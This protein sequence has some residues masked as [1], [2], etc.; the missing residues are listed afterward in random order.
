M[1]RKKLKDSSGYSMETSENVSLDNCI[2]G[3]EYRGELKEINKHEII[4]KIAEMLGSTPYE[5]G[6]AE[7][8]FNRMKYLIANYIINHEYNSCKGI[9]TDLLLWLD[10]QSDSANSRKLNKFISRYMK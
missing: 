10:S 1:K 3:D 4:V 6:K 9:S 7:R 5:L 2:F 8:I